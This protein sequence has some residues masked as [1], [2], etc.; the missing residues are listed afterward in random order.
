MTDTE[1][2]SGSGRRKTSRLAIA[3]AVL[4]VG[5]PVL[6]FFFLA[7][8]FWPSR[9]SLFIHDVAWVC[10]LAGVVLAPVAVVR[11]VK[12]SHML[13]R[14]KLAVTG[15]IVGVL[16]SLGCFFDVVGSTYHYRDPR[17]STSCSAH[18]RKLAKAMVVYANDDEYGRFPTPDKWCDLLLESGEVSEEDFICPER[19]LFLPF[20]TKP[21]LILPVPRK[22]RC[23]YAMNP[24]AHAADLSPGIV[25]L[26]E[27]TEGW[28]K[29]G[30]PELLTTHRHGGDG[31][32]AAFVDTHVSFEKDPARLP[33]TAEE[34]DQERRSRGYRLF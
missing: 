29:F 22:G 8:F 13:S 21:V 32:N 24:N 18:L 16:F 14:A 5:V 12:R 25:L 34:A 20:T 33:W 6:F 17:W 26:F 7:P 23:H 30:G 1:N 10:A 28:N 27:T 15:G 3:A 9:V 11:V 2:D 19:V 4:G 31:C